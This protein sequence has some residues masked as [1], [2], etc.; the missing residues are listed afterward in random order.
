MNVERLKKT[1]EGA[2]L[3]AVSTLAVISAVASYVLTTE[4]RLTTVF[5]Y[6]LGLAVGLTFLLIFLNR[7][8]LKELSE[9][10]RTV[11]KIMLWIK[12]KVPK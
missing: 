12:K 7:D 11:L 4:E 5:T 10:R 1:F 2:V 6:T 9:L 8:K 3:A